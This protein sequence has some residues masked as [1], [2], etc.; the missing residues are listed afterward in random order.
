[1]N[2]RECD[3]IWNCRYLTTF[4]KECAVSTFRVELGGRVLLRNIGKYLSDYASQ[5]TYRSLVG[6]PEGNKPLGRQRRRW[7]DDIKIDLGEI[8]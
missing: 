1:M 4:P 3:V 7:V 8:G 5:T 6:E 2:N